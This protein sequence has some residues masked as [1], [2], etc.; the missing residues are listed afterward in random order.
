MRYCLTGTHSTGKS[1][2]LEALKEDYP[3]HYF[4]IS[5]TREVTSKQERKLEEVTEETQNKILSGIEAREKE[6]VEIEKEQDIIMD[7]SFIDFAAYTLVFGKQGKI[8]KE[9]AEEIVLGCKRRI[10]SM[11]DHIFYLPIE[12]DLVDDGVRSTDESLRVEVD[13]AIQ[14]ILDGASNV[15]KL[16]GSVDER[17]NQIRNIIS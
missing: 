10:N 14:A 13:N 12:F 16:T 7:R 6:L 9:F 11:Y 2:L 8:S 17:R 3:N 4:N 5:S 15:T 1:T